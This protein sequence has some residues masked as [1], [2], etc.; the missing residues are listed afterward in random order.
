MLCLYRGARGSLSC[1]ARANGEAVGPYREA[2]EM[3]WDEMEGW[4]GSDCI[5]DM[6]L[7]EGE[8]E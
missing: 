1:E 6:L 3:G 2:E 8:G 5:L 4:E 7:S